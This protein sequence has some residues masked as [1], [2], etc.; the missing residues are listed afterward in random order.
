MLEASS[1]YRSTS[2]ERRALAM[3]SVFGAVPIEVMKDLRL[4]VPIKFTRV[5]AYPRVF[6]WAGVVR[7]LLQIAPELD[8]VCSYTP[9]L[10]PTACALARVAASSGS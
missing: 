8:A 6:S 7:P 5:H 1:L 9:A 3:V 2:T 10:R 4:S